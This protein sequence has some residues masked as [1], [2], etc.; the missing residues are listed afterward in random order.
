MLLR[1]NRRTVLLTSAI[2][3]GNLAACSWIDARIR[4]SVFRP[5]RR[6]PADFRG[7]APS[8]QVF[9]LPSGSGPLA[10]A[11]TLWWLP[12]AHG[13]APGLLYLHGTFRNL[14]RN[15][16]KIL[17]IREAGFSVLAVDYRGWGDSAPI[18]PSEQTIYED[19][20]VAWQE[21][22]RRL[23]IANKCAI[24]GHS[25]GGG[26]ATWLATQVGSGPAGASALIIESSFT[27]LPD[28][29]KAASILGYPAAL[30]SDQ[31]FDSASRIALVAM[32]LLVMHGSS[33]STVPFE[34]GERLFAAAVAPKEFVAFAQGSHSELHSENAPL[35]QQTL[36]R[37][38]ASLASSN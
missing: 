5:D 19:A 22:R 24:F 1:M 33:D 25:M 38:A 2:A 34:L 17:A 7:L 12:H 9:S 37:W 18:L 30:L 13:N 20:Q 32:P 29:A 31:Q 11:M 3:A 14:Y 15:Y 4:A 28:V 26:V 27:N 36:R 8:D 21:L 23:P 16:P 35:Y 10:G 6:I